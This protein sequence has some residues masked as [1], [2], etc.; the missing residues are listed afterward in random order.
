MKE[1]SLE[2]SV[3]PQEEE[4]TLEEKR[5][6]RPETV[7]RNQLKINLADIA[8]TAME[9]QGFTIEEG[10]Y[11]SSENKNVITAKE[12]LKTDETLKEV[13]SAYRAKIKNF[14]GDEITIET[15]LWNDIDTKS[16]DFKTIA[17]ALGQ[18]KEWYADQQGQE[19]GLRPFQVDLGN[20]REIILKRAPRY[21]P[22]S[23]SKNPR[24]DIYYMLVEMN[25]KDKQVASTLAKLEQEAGKTI[26]EVV[27]PFGSIYVYD[28]MQAQFQKNLE[29]FYER[30]LS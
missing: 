30:K 14:S 3:A 1:G 17:K 2:K 26:G 27:A 6:A 22:T 19:D 21:V 24:F 7:I 25:Y 28:D 12:S 9:R 4:M 23:S 15:G 10:D 11:I 13:K 18:N 8:V 16:E 29:E 5:A 20:G